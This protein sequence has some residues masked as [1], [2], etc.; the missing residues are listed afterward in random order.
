VG[1]VQDAHIFHCHHPPKKIVKDPDH[2][3]TLTL[4]SKNKKEQIQQEVETA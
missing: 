2:H 4:I 1:R 3:K